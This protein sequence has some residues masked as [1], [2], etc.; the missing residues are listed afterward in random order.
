MLRS[1]Y[2]TP[3]VA[4]CN[5]TVAPVRARYRSPSTSCGFLFLLQDAHQTWRKGCRLSL[6]ITYDKPNKQS[7][8]V[9][10]HTFMPSHFPQGNPASTCT[11]AR[12]AEDHLRQSA[13][14]SVLFLSLGPERRR[15]GFRYLFLIEEVY[16]R[17]YSPH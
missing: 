4:C 6:V 16:G 13:R 1:I 11:F 12:S 10:D 9:H 3:A 7:R 17:I 15:L 8:Y 5:Q 2:T 14:N